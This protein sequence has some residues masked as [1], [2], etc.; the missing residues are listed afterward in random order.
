MSSLPLW[1]IPLLGLVLLSLCGGCGSDS[2]DAQS[3]TSPSVAKESDEKESAD[4]KSAAKD[5]ETEAK[6]STDS[7]TAETAQQARSDGEAQPGPAT[8]EAT[9]L[10]HKNA[11]YESFKAARLAEAERELKAALAIRSD[12]HQLNRAL[13]MLLN[14]EGRRWEAG[15]YGFAL[16]KARRFSIE[17]LALLASTDEVYDNAPLLQAALRAEPASRIPL[18]GLARIDRAKKRESE[19][20]EKLEQVLKSHPELAEAHA[21][22][23]SLLLDLNENDTFLAW[24]SSLPESALEH[25]EIW[26]TFGRWAE[27]NAQREA[28]ARCY[29]ETLHRDAQHRRAH[30]QLAVVLKQLGREQEAKRLLERSRLLGELHEMVH[31][32]VLN[33]P[34]VKKMQSIIELCEATGRIWEAWAW[35]AATVHTMKSQGGAPESLV[36]KRDQLKQRIDPAKTPRTLA[37]FILSEQIR[38][39]DFDLPRWATEKIA[40]GPQREAGESSAIRWD[41][42]ARAAKLTFTYFDSA[43]A[44]PDGIQIMDSTGG[45][46]AILDYDQDGWPDVYLT[47]CRPWPPDG[48]L[49]GETSAEFRDRLFRNRGD[50]TFEDVTERVGIDERRFSQGCASGDFNNDG[51]PDIY[52]ANIGPN[53][54][55]VNNG[56]GTFS[57]GSLPAE[58]GPLIWS[59]SCAVVDLNG[60]GLPDLFD[61]NYLGGNVYTAR[62]NTPQRQKSCGP[63]A[64]PGEQDRVLINQGDGTW[65]DATVP[66]RLAGTIGK[67]L[68]IAV[69]DFNLDGRM[70]VFVANDGEANFL[71]VDRREKTGGLPQWRDDALLQGLAFNRDGEGQACM[72]IAIDD[73][74]GD[75]RLDLFITNYYDDANTLYLQELDGL[76]VDKT[77][78]AEL[79]DPSLKL[80]GF[81]TQFLDADLDGAPDLLI[82]N[83]HVDNL[84][85]EGQPFH[86]PPQA[87]VNLH[88]GLFSELPSEQAGDYFNRAYLGRGMA[89]VDWNRD[90]REDA[91]VS[92]IGS[93]VSLVT[94][95]TQTDH[96]FVAFRLRGRRGARDAYGAT[97][98]VRH[99]G[100]T[101]MKQLTAGNGYQACN[102][103]RLVFGLGDS[104][105]I[106]EIRIRWPSGD[107][108][109]FTGPKVDREWLAIEGGDKLIAVGP[110]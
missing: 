41:D 32:I 74:D 23:G 69:A 18:L 56:D 29:W 99:A 62:C 51:W 27:Q 90:G 63:S 24:R 88:D 61:V 35:S 66:S 83:G 82:A 84:S 50:G 64:F 20:R 39:A 71:F 31:P 96:H 44:R 77:R 9:F 12:D 52:V 40:G 81:G 102:E 7:S 13:A 87:F 43:K 105:E 104:D 21:Q 30:F 60:D 19:A 93:P 89:V 80:L 4:K 10:L 1:T 49:T 92:N 73:A 95:R 5:P 101:R 26:F 100:G 72:G 48:P 46:V 110:E 55:F 106:A 47:Q 37:A 86:M 108:A 38:L 76:F 45:G 91:V 79:F 97:V 16:V 17:D 53:R 54:L 70:E 107:E 28:A 2:R 98:W 11:A 59:T 68:G 103:R 36:A 67:G 6:P 58:S 109:T 85:Y 25:P 57:P 94:N 22:Y 3:S 75:G 8:D 78:D 65:R 15:Q 14:S 42:L 33:G 34:D